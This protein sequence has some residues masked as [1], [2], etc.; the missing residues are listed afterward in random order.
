LGF[1]LYFELSVQPD[2]IP[3]S[4]SDPNF[5]ELMKKQRQIQETIQSEY[6]RHRV[7]R[8]ENPNLPKYDTPIELQDNRE[9][10]P[11]TDE[12]VVVINPSN[13]VQNAIQK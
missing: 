6:Q 11:S 4:K 10:P 1:E 3:M 2:G 9:L 8:E 5:H 12:E 7:E 13:E